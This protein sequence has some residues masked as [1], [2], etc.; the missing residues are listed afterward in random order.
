MK[1]PN[2]NKQKRDPSTAKGDGESVVLGNIAEMS[3]N[4]RANG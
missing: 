2:L 4:D 3:E 1:K